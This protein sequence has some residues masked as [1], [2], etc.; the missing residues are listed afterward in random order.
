[1]TAP[2]PDSGLPTR[3]VVSDMLNFFDQTYAFLMGLGAIT[4]VIAWILNMRSRDIQRMSDIEHNANMISSRVDGIITA[5]T[6]LVAA[7]RS[8]ES[9]IRGYVLELAKKPDREEMFDRIDAIPRQVA[10]V[11]NEIKIRSLP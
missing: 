7:Q 2:S 10:S 1:M 5:Q 4:G 9:T 6:E 11:L 3:D 8:L